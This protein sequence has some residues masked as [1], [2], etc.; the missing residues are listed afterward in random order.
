MKKMFVFALLLMWG[1]PTRSEAKWAL[2]CQ[3]VVNQT[4]DFRPSFHPG[5]MKDIYQ[6]SDP[7]APG[8]I[9]EGSSY[10]PPPSPS[11]T[12]TAQAERDRASLVSLESRSARRVMA[13]IWKYKLTGPL[14]TGVPDESQPLCVDGSGKPLTLDEFMV[15]IQER[16]DDGASNAELNNL[17]AIAKDVRKYFR[18][19]KP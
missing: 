12:A 19:L 9:K 10:L 15:Y 7:V 5:I 14:T 18:T 3:G 16:E 13:S 17:K 4:W 1:A 2:V 6:V 11:E 8:W